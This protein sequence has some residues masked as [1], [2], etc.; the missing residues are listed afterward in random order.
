MNWIKTKISEI[1]AKA[2]KIFKR[3][4]KLTQ[5]AR[6]GKAAQDAVNS[7]RRIF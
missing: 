6:F 2:K 5:A 7:T 4:E 3:Q 1:K